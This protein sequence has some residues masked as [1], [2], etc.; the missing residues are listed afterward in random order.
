MFGWIVQVSFFSII[1]IFLI[2]HILIFFKE[3]LTVPKVKDIVSS[4]NKQYS[5][6]FSTMNYSTSS[7]NNASY[8]PIDLLPEND[9]D[10]TTIAN[11]IANTNLNMSNIETDMKNEL[12]SFLKQ[13][14]K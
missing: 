11:T 13:Q 3:T 10:N 12:K 2:H 4:T 8:T 5:E 9:I 14:L 7:D 1:F 6:I